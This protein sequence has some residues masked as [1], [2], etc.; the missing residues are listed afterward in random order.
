[1]INTKTIIDTA[2][3]IS[4]LLSSLSHEEL[5]EFVKELNREASDYDFTKE[6][7]DYFFDEMED[8][9]EDEDFE[10]LTYTD[11]D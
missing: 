5:V 7:R 8:E 1:M 10:H 4:D 11:D 9:E 6:L 3:I 2:E